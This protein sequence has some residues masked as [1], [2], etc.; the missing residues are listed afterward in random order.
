[1]WLNEVMMELGWEQERKRGPGTC[2]S[3]LSALGETR[4]T[5]GERLLVAILAEEQDPV[6]AA[7]FPRGHSYCIR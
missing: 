6:V 2:S 1:M 4:L 7:A 3:D 5:L